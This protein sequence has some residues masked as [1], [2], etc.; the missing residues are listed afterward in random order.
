MKKILLPLASIILGFSSCDEVPPTV[1][2][3][4]YECNSP[5]PIAQPKRVIIEEFTGAQ[6]VNCPDG[7]AQIGSMLA[8]YPNNLIAVSIHTGFFSVPFPNATEDLTFAQGEDIN[9]LVGNVQGYPAAVIDR[10]LFPN[11]ASRI[12]NQT[13]WAGKV[14]EALLEPPLVN[15]DITNIV[16]DPIGRTVAFDVEVHCNA[17][18]KKAIAVSAMITQDS[19]VQP[20]ETRNGVVDNYVHK[21]VL[22]ALQP[23]IAGAEVTALPFTR[24]FTIPFGAT[25]DEHHCHIVAFAHTADGAGG[26]ITV[27]QAAEEEV[28]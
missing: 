15:V 13:K 1:R 3:A 16:W 11:E 26:D 23:G 17:D 4:T 5:A 25:W 9:Q 28:F 21:H 6:C 10:R 2:L 24:H 22:R 7:A 27:L 8:Q 18:V 14:A 12:L 19:I 20:Q